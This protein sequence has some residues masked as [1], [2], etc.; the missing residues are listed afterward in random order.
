MKEAKK[1]KSPLVSIIIPVYNVEKYVEQCILSLLNQTYSNIEII[2]VN[3]GSKDES[4]QKILDLAKKD[5]RI[6]LLNQENKGV[7]AARNNGL[8]SANGDFIIFVDADDYLKEDFVEYMLKLINKDA[9]DFAYSIK[10]FQSEKENKQKK[11]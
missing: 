11:K 9:A 1:E 8:N 4:P 10:S 3:D 7:S 5:K 2:A 6:K